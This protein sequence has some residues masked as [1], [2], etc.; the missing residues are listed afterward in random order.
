MSITYPALLYKC[1][2]F[3]VILVESLTQWEEY[4]FSKVCNLR[5]EKVT[6]KSGEYFSLADE[7]GSDCPYIM[8]YDL[9][10]AI[11]G[12]NYDRVSYIHN[13]FD[14]ETNTIIQQ[15]RTNEIPE[16]IQLYDCT[17]SKILSIKVKYRN[18][19]LLDI[20][21]RFKDLGSNYSWREIHHNSLYSKLFSIALPLQY[22]CEY[23]YDIVDK[24]LIKEYSKLGN[25]Y[26]FYLTWFMKEIRDYIRVNYGNENYQKE[27]LGFN[28]TDSYMLGYEVKLCVDAWLYGKIDFNTFIISLS[29]ALLDSDF[30]SSARG[31]HDR[32]K[33][34]DYS[35]IFNDF[36]K[37]FGTD[38][39]KLLVFGKNNLTLAPFACYNIG[40]Y[41]LC[42]RNNVGVSPYYLS[43]LMSWIFRKSWIDSNN[44]ALRVKK[45]FTTLY[46]GVD[47]KTNSKKNTVN[48]ISLSFDFKDIFDD[49]I[50]LN[51]NCSDETFNKLKP[52]IEYA[53]LSYM[54]CKDRIHNSISAFNMDNF[55]LHLKSDRQGV[56]ME[57][58][59]EQ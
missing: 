38:I 24:Y 58:T 42:I 16:T 55:N 53:F 26:M 12:E 31:N 10:P 49:D 46:N 13:I 9:C 23:V 54:I 47:S 18:D 56:V 8:I 2:Y 59:Y 6:P 32:D 40:A 29:V 39:I 17:N 30:T 45:Y 44:P 1:D 20:F 3:I 36:D 35:A 15:V 21:T 19:T 7:Y 41:T 5:Y 33:L 43:V 51:V 28:Y 52:Y 50:E 25:G 11:L 34:L 48:T 37:L 57:Y 27:V 14:F 22:F 4:N